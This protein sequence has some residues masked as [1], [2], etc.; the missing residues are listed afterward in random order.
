MMEQTP[1]VASEGAAEDDGLQCPKTF[2]VVMILWL[3]CAAA[4][5]YF[6]FQCIGDFTDG[7][8]NGWSLGGRIGFYTANVF[9]FLLFFGMGFGFPGWAVFI[10][11]MGWGNDGPGARFESFNINTTMGPC[12]RLANMSHLDHWMIPIA[13]STACLLWLPYPKIQAIASGLCVLCGAYMFLWWPVNLLDGNIMFPKAVGDPTLLLFI[14]WS[15]VGLSRAVLFLPPAL[16]IYP[17]GFTLAICGILLLMII[18]GV[19]GRGKVQ[20]VWALTVECLQIL[21]LEAS[22]VPWPKGKRFPKGWAWEPPP[23]GDK[24]GW[25]AGPWP[26]DSNDCTVSRAKIDAAATELNSITMLPIQVSL[27]ILFLLVGTFIALICTA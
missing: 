21:S 18:V 6:N 3:A 1:L 8:G 19:C 17:L 4:G 7:C 5:I 10:F 15:A 23:F 25:P 2:G 16:T 24:K 27:A 11:T 26:Y 22:G 9:A 14:F 13:T 12:Y 20:N